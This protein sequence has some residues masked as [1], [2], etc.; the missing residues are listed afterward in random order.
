MRTDI[1]IEPLGPDRLDDYFYLFD[2]IRFAENPHWSACYC[3]SFHFTGVAE[4]WNRESNRIAVTQLIN[5]GGMK[6]YLA[7]KGQQPVGWCNANN[8]SNYQRLNKLYDLPDSDNNNICTIVCFLIHQEF[9]RLGIARL[10]LESVE[11]DCEALGYSLIEAY[12][13]KGNLSCEKNYKGPLDLYLSKG[14]NI[15]S[16]HENYFIV[17]KLIE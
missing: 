4:E 7:Y 6:G 11:S 17:R 15:E 10:L 8:R 5:D 12:P 9:R 13:G 1:T 2:N 3:Y 16:E 14:F